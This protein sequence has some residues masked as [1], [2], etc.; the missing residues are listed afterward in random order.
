MILTLA[1]Q[2]QWLS[3]I[4]TWNI[5]VPSTGFAPMTSVM[6]VQCSDQ[7]S[8]EVIQTWAGQFFGIMCSLERNEFKHEPNKLTYSHLSGF[9]AQLVRALH[10]H[11]WGHGFK[12]H[13]RIL[14]FSDAH[15][16]QSLWL[17]SRCGSFLQFIS[18]PHFTNF[19]FFVNWN[20]F[21]Q[22]NIHALVNLF[23]WQRSCIFVKRSGAKDRGHIARLTQFISLCVCPVSMLYTG[24]SQKLWDFFLTCRKYLSSQETWRN[25]RTE[26]ACK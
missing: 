11:H 23:F 2:S 6:P 16:K 5:Q 25:E 17:S 9:I 14:N 7:L 26:H 24:F 20:N 22:H 19:Y 15:V 13:V 21:L 10:R 18:Q 12:S 1:G 3:H 8:Y 4:Y